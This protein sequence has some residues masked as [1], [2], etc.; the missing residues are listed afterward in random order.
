[1]K[2]WTRYDLENLGLRCD[3]EAGRIFMGDQEL[4]PCIHVGPSGLAYPKVNVYDPDLWAS[5]MARKDRLKRAYGTRAIHAAR[6]VWAFAYGAVPASKMVKAING[7]PFD[8]R[9]SN[10]KLVNRRKEK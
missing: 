10:L 6:I 4:V 7:N 9:I 3:P 5:T 8:L 2:N 1:M